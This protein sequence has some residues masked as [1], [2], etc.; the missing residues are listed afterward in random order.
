MSYV[1]NFAIVIAVTTD[2]AKALQIAQEN[3]SDSGGRKF[4]S[5]C[6]CPFYKYMQTL[7]TVLAC[8]KYFCVLRML[9]NP[10]RNHTVGREL[11]DLLFSI[12]QYPENN[13]INSEND[14]D[15]K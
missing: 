14:R 12:I 3:A 2:S 11:Q 13:T 7:T 9:K 8:R 15:E 5:C 6:S 4:D 10:Q 1:A